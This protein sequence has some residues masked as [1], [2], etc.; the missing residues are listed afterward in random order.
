MPP[1]F[2]P[3]RWGVRRLQGDMGAGLSTQQSGPY[4][5]KEAGGGG[6]SL[7]GQP[8]NQQGYPKDTETQGSQ[9]GLLS[10]IKESPKLANLR[11]SD[12]IF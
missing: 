9:V 1:A 11:A 12:Q 5:R 10:R 7:W 8:S 2:S 6:C 3:Q 4:P